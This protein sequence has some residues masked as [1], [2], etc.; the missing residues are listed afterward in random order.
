MYNGECNHSFFDWYLSNS[1]SNFYSQASPQSGF[2]QMDW[3]IQIKVG[4]LGRTWNLNS[5]KKTI[6]KNPPT[7]TGNFVW[8]IHPG[9]HP[10]VVLPVS[11]PQGG[12]RARSR[13]DFHQS[14]VH[15]SPAYGEGSAPKW[16]LGRFLSWMDGFIWNWWGRCFFQMVMFFF[17]GGC[18]FPIK[19]QWYPKMDGL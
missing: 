11:P 14:L 6:P 15:P 7:K 18:F 16:W 8:G 10:K 13:W 3:F 12:S 17:P 2:P 19:K 1:L 5:L 9:V 4:W